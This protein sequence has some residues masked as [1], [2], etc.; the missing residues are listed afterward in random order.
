MKKSKAYLINGVFSKP[1][2][3]CWEVGLGGI[4]GNSCRVLTL[5]I[6]SVMLLRVFYGNGNDHKLVFSSSLR[7]DISYS[8]SIQVMMAL[9]FLDTISAEF[10]VWI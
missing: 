4:D 2:G 3:L 10:E 9:L 7:G 1:G 6:L 5:A 8:S